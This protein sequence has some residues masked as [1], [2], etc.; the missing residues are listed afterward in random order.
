MMESTAPL[1][2]H[3][4]AHSDSVPRKP[5]RSPLAPRAIARHITLAL[6]NELALY[7]KPGLVSLRDAGAHGDM[8]ANTF[9]RS[10]F[11]L[12]HQFTAIAAAGSC[13]APFAELRDLGIRAEVAMLAATEGVNTHRGAIFALGLLGASAALAGARG[14]SLTDDT[15]RSTLVIQ[16][17]AALRAFPPA[18]ASHGTRMAERYGASGARGEAI[19]GFPA[20]FD[21]ALPALRAA[22]WGGCD[23]R[24]TRLAAFFALLQNVG[25]TNVLHRGGRA[26]LIYVRDS[27][28]AFDAAGGV[29]APD[30]L[31]RAE[32]IHR[33]FIAR[34]L[35][36]GGC[37]D[38]LAATLLVDALQAQGA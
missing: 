30:A 36:P 21:V 3:N 27:A 38:L 18:T 17:G 4:L 20:V 28:R 16:W 19:A 9:V 22:R 7:P 26:G 37:A 12:R 8:D 34:G 6:W 1:A 10:L 33:N 35:S 32:A 15:L 31:E 14:D 25:D 5:T 13:G 23:V 2:P 24:R 29:D 11:A